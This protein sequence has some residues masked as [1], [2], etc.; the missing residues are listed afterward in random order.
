MDTR[1]EE[2]LER[3]RA[4]V[5]IDEVFPELKESEDERIRK[6]CIHFLGL[7]KAHHADTSEIDECISYLEKQ[8]EQKPAE[9]SEEFLRLM[10]I[11]ISQDGN[12][13][14]VL[15]GENLAEGI[16]GFGDT[17]ADAV[18]EFKKEWRQFDRFRKA[19]WKPSKEQMNALK[20][21]KMRMS[22]DGYGLCPLLQTLIND[23]KSL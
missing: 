11:T 15:L 22:L 10:G 3:A 16:A 17:L 4:G 9:W 12:Q 23:L 13:V 2:A 21:A 18:E 20:D 5:P 19:T 8:K 7:Q 6:N 14:C 1:Y